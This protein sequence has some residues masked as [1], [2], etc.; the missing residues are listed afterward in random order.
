MG[1]AL[2]RLLV[3][4]SEVVTVGI[5]GRVRA[6]CARVVSLHYIMPDGRLLTEGETTMPGGAVVPFTTEEC[7]SYFIPSDVTAPRITYRVGE[8]VCA[9]NYTPLGHGGIHMFNSVRALR[10]AFPHAL[11]NVPIGTLVAR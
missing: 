9:P 1:F 2:A 7:V 6:Q 10:A 11:R 4:E 8:L 3:P 5:S